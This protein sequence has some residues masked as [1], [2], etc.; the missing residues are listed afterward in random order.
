MR[1]FRTRTILALAGL[2]AALCLGIAPALAQPDAVVPAAA[3]SDA[4]PERVP[5]KSGEGSLWYEQ[6]GTLQLNVVFEG[7]LKSTPPPG[8]AVAVRLNESLGDAEPQVRAF[9]RTLDYVTI[10]KQA[11]FE[12]TTL[13]DY[14]QTMVLV[15]AKTDRQAWHLHKS[16]GEAGCPVQMPR[17]FMVGDVAADNWK[18]LLKARL[19]EEFRARELMSLKQIPGSWQ[20][21]TCLRASTLNL[22]SSR[23]NEPN[24]VDG[25]QMAEE[26]SG[27]NP[28][29]VEVSNRGPRPLHVYFG[30]IDDSRRFAIKPLR[31]GEDRPLIPGEQI[32]FTHRVTSIDG[33]AYFITLASEAPLDLKGLDQAGAFGPGFE[34]TIC[35]S[36]PSAESETQ[37]PDAPLPSGA[38]YANSIAID[39]QPE[40]VCPAMGGGDTALMS[41]APWMAQ[42]YDT[43]QFTPA[44]IA[45]DSQRANQ[46]RIGLRWLS[47]EQRE[48]HC[49][50]TL[51][52]PGLVLTAAHCVAEGSFA[53]ANEP[54]ARQTLRVRT[55]SIELG[56]GRSF[57]IDSIAVHAG[58]V[59][60]RNGSDIALIKLKAMPGAALPDK[61]VALSENS[62]FAPGT[63]FNTFGWGFSGEWLSGRG[64]P[65]VSVDGLQ[66]MPTENLR[67][68]P[69]EAIAPQRCPVSLRVI[70][71]ASPRGRERQV[72]TCF[73]D[74]GGPLI[75]TREGRQE[76]VGVVNFSKGCSGPVPT[77]FAAVASYGRWIDAAKAWLAQNPGRV[78]RVSDPAL[79]N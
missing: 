11:D 12:L 30:S 6:C 60:E 10:T 67:Y 46:D 29:Q 1:D 51:V 76:L 52:G 8:N 4:E 49:G 45:R 22:C 5:L 71:A 58:F 70:C 15:D 40:A 61:A 32:S 23:P 69:L 54:K 16:Q 57:G 59:A 7:L 72:F 25:V 41:M 73:K 53:A 65:H 62:V 2:I 13:V 55:G 24:V 50:G 20:I 79:A 21:E 37:P 75:R 35:Q 47:P 27:G 44:Q 39:V 33:P 31:D 42:L 78:G 64:N 56:G 9:L 18:T 14:P 34:L 68:G 77:A 48:H 63:T 26:I 17:Q 66:Q 28:M 38:A 36:R 19:R 3:A 43:R 74:S